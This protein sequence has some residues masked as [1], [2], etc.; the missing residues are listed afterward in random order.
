MSVANEQMPYL[1]CLQDPED[2]DNDLGRN[3]WRILDIQRTFQQLSKHIKGWLGDF[4]PIAHKGLTPL[5]FLLGTTLDVVRDR[6]DAFRLWSFSAKGRYEV[7]MIN[8]LAKEVIAKLEKTN[9]ERVADAD[10][11]HSV[12]VEE[13]GTG[14]GHDDYDENMRLEDHKNLEESRQVRDLTSTNAF[15][16]AVA[17]RD[18]R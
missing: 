9:T 14:V 4:G 6:R 16:I 7:K 8:N 17:N 3:A 11:G 5:E 2:P 1:L 10:Q 13:S 18:S 15:V 12:S